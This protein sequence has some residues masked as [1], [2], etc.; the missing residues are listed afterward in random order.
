MQQ[1]KFAEL[2]NACPVTIRRIYYSERGANPNSV[3]IANVKLT[4]QKLS[5]PFKTVSRLPAPLWHQMLHIGCSVSLTQ[6][7]CVLFDGRDHQIYPLIFPL[8]K[9]PIPACP[10]RKASRNK[11]SHVSGLPFPGD[12]CLTIPTHGCTGQV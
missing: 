8:P 5:D 7:G 11:S 3:V 2:L 10:A 6:P 9:T 1:K 4:K 12:V